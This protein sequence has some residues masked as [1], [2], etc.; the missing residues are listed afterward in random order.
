[1]YN[2]TQGVLLRPAC[3][4]PVPLHAAP[5]G[6]CARAANLRR[7]ATGRARA[8]RHGRGRGARGDQG[9]QG[10]GLS[11]IRIRYLVPRMLLFVFFVSCLAILRIE[12]CLNSLNSA[13]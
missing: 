3:G 8:E 4:G 1:M 9:F 5:A 6:V 10:C 13:P 2:A 12:G 11:M 7:R